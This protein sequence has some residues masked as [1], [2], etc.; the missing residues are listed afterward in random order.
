MITDANFLI[1]FKK[2]FIPMIA[3]II[4]PFVVY[5]ISYIFTL[6]LNMGLKGPALGISLGN[7]AA[8]III[9]YKLRHLPEA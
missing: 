7:G 5:V 8:A 4:V 2:P 6:K 9:N 3:H 1:S